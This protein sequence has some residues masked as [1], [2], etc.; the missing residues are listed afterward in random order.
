MDGPRMPI[1]TL[2]IGGKPSSAQKEFFQRTY[3]FACM[4]DIHNALRLS[5]QRLRV[6][7]CMDDN[8]LACWGGV[9]YVD[10]DRPKARFVP[11]KVVAN[12]AGIQ[13]ERWK[14]ATSKELNAF[15]KTAWKEP[16]QELWS[17]YFATKRKVVMQLLVFNL[18][19]ITAEKKTMGLL[20]GE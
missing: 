17:R 10:E 19:P 16:T 3:G 18:K 2:H 12:A 9:R 6:S 5:L 14:Q 13:R 1:D 15:L 4:M 8:I 20:G 7:N 11:N